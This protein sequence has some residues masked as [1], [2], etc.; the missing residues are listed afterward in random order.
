M[1]EQPTTTTSSGS[2]IFMLTLCSFIWGTAFIAQS[3]GGQIMGPMTFNGS[4]SILAT[5]FLLPAIFIFDHFNG[6]KCSFWG[7][8]DPAE[9]KKLWRGGIICG[10]VLTIDSLF[11]QTG[12]MYTSVGKG[13]FITSLYIII[14]PLLGRFVF[15]RTVNILQ[16]ISVAVASVGMYFICLN[17]SFSINK[18][19]MFILG[20]AFFFAMHILSVEHFAQG[21]DG[22]RLSFFQFA[23]CT[24]VNF[25]LMFI[26]EKPTLQQ[27]ELALLPI[28]YAG[29]MSSGIAYT[30][31]IIGQ[32]RVNVVLATI[33][34]SLESV[35]AVLSGWLILNQI[36][37]MREIFGCLLVFAAIM[38]AQLPPQ[39][40]GIKNKT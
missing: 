14:V 15:G 3:L 5:L 7:T 29:I 36:L 33:L 10:L 8:K 32:T 39:L 38:L 27:V 19:D 21:V 23:T 9:R 18:G 1:N 31:Q 35:F 34:L 25:I 12:M 20:S 17:E 16:W 37:T 30:L 13:G 28:C 11:Q 6:K 26:F 2:G 4:R 40:L 22:V 24:V